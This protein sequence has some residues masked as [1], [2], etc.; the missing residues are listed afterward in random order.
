MLNYIAYL[1]LAQTLEM[2]PTSVVILFGS[3]A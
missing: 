3:M 1:Q 2:Q